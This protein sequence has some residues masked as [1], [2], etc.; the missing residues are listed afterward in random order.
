MQTTSVNSLLAE[1]NALPPAE[2][3]LAAEIIGRAYA[4]QRRS[5][6]LAASKRAKR[7]LESGKVKRGTAEDLLRDIDHD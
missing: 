7:N 5:E 3:A 6:I 2:R 1:F 4:E